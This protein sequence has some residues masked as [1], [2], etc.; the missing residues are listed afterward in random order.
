MQRG[1]IGLANQNQELLDLN[2][3]LTEQLETVVEELNLLKKEREEKEIRKEA[4]VNRKRL[5]K[6]H[7]MISEIYKGL[8]RAA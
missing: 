6:R 2:K 8:I 3:Q 5:P 1:F 4:R 7:P